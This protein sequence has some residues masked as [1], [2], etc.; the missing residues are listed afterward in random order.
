MRRRIASR[1]TIAAAL[2]LTIALASC[3]RRERA[4]EEAPAEPGPPRDL[5]LLT[6]DT[7]RADRAGCFGNPS[8]LTPSIDRALRHALLVRDAYAPAPLTAVSHATILSGLEPYHHGV[9]DN[10]LFVLSD[11]VT[12]LA[13]HLSKHGFRTAGFVAGYPLVKRFG[14]SQ[15]FAT[16]DDT[17]G[18]DPGLGTYYAERPAREVVDRVLAWIRGLAPSDRAFVWAHFFDPHH[19]Y[20]PLPALRRLPVPGDYEREIRGMDVQIGRLLHGLEEAGRRP[21]LAI[22]SDHGEGLGEHR[23]VTHG[24]LLHEE[25]LHGV[26]GIA[27]PRGSELA[28]KL[29]GVRVTVTGYPDL[30]PTL[31][32]ALGVE[33]MPNV[34]G[35]SLLG[36]TEGSGVYGETYDPML[37]YRWSPLLCWRDDRW[38]YV[39]GPHA[40]LFD[41]V[42]D[43]AET[44]NVAAEHADVVEAFSRKIGAVESPPAASSGEPLD[45]EARRKLAALG[46]LGTQ[47]AGY[48]AKKDPKDYIDVL[49]QLFHGILLVS[50]SKES[51]ALPFLRAAYAAD[52]QNSMAVLYLG[53]TYRKLG[54]LASATT[55]FQKAIELDPRSAEAWAHLALIRYDRG[56]TPEA[57]GLVEKGLLANPDSFALLMTAGFLHRKVGRLREAQREY[58]RA[59]EVEPK[60]AEPL[61]ELASLADG[62]GDAAEARTLRD[63]AGRL[64][65]E[66]PAAPPPGA[67]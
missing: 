3:A 38:S 13:E 12:T 50:E 53:M 1:A 61:S 46:Y 39:E 20:Q 7:F 54:D 42:T 21:L 28:A 55:Y 4:R 2:A 27:A 47:Q 5:V 34:D 56:E 9:R 22:I 49:N 41:R 11:S 6:L 33:P 44:K 32:D 8:G 45:A 26:L 57:I 36:A 35:A 24:I 66:G 60:R 10:G 65:A 23:E 14:F 51:E 40:E 52:P 64:A 63:R 43:P 15:G 62:R 37:H 18:P 58:E 25:T 31:L 17:L 30:A 59:A 19:P 48:D 67:E 29:R 16:F